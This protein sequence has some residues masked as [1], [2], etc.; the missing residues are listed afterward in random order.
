VIHHDSS[1][2]DILGGKPLGPNENVKTL[3][4]T[5]QKLMP[6]VTGLPTGPKVLVSIIAVVLTALFLVLIWTP[7]RA[8]DTTKDPARNPR[9]IQAYT[10]MERVLSPLA[11]RQDG[12]VVVHGDPVSNRLQQY[13]I[14]YAR[15]AMYIRGHPNDIKGAYEEVWNNGGESR[16]FID[17]TQTYEAVVSN[18]FRTYQEAENESLNTTSP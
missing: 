11:I 15:I 13:Y 5:L 4:E 8:T 7:E 9:V 14:P 10:R 17:D 2:L 18:F 1:L 12:T 16:I 3:V 6:W